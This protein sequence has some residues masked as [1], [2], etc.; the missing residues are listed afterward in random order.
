MALRQRPVRRI[1]TSLRAEGVAG[2]TLEG[3]EEGVQDVPLRLR[4][5]PERAHRR[6][7][8]ARLVEAIGLETT[9]AR[10]HRPIPPL[11]R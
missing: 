2:E 1:R 5:R 4:L 11:L 7:L 3:T 9:V 6:H 8:K 10:S